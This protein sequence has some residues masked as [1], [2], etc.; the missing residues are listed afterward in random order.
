M[1]YKQSKQINEDK[2]LKTGI[3]KLCFNRKNLKESL[4]TLMKKHK[5][6]F[7]YFSNMFRTMKFK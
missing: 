4:K 1:D 3:F 5:E 7:S 2:E 6:C